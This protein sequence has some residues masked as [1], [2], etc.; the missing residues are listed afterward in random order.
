MSHGKLSVYSAQTAAFMYFP[1]PRH[2]QSHFG[3]QNSVLQTTSI[4]LISID[5]LISDNHPGDLLVLTGENLG[6]E[7]AG[8]FVQ[9]V[10]HY[11]D[12]HW[13]L[14][15]TKAGLRTFTTHIPVDVPAGNYYLRVCCEHGSLEES[16][17]MPFRVLESPAGSMPGGIAFLD[18]LFEDLDLPGEHVMSIC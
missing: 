6:S 1:S 8:V 9:L 16:E 15:R 13:N 10:S 17:L 3:T 7:R 18:E 14:I 4:P 5:E 11:E 12:Q 2:A